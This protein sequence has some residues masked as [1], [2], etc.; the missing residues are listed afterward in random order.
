M[1][2]VIFITSV[3]PLDERVGVGPL[4]SE[5]LNASSDGWVNK[6]VYYRVATSTTTRTLDLVSFFRFIVEISY[7]NRWQ[8][9]QL[10]GR[11][12]TDYLFVAS[13]CLI[14]FPERF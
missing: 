7:E 1:R 6:L 4:Q 8:P 14:S 12:N 9:M 5:V 2:T 13:S 10:S 11:K 3:S